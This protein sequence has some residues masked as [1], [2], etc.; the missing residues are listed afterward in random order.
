MRRG[1]HLGGLAINR[2]T[3]SAALLATAVA[4]PVVLVVAFLVGESGSSGGTAASPSSTPPPGPLAT[5]VPA[6]AADVVT[7]CAPVLAAVPVVLTDGSG[8]PPLQ[9]LVV[10]PGGPTFVAWGN[11]LVTLQCG[12]GRPSW[13]R[14]DIDYGTPQ[15]ITAPDGYGALWV[16]EPGAGGRTT[17]TVID[18]PVYL[19]ATLPSDNAAYLTDLSS[20]IGRTLPPVCSTPQPDDAPDAVY[21]G[22]RP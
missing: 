1:Q 19:R 14:D 10:T 7:A 22:A 17:W 13:L 15:L 20:A 3:R 2:S 4:L 16:A 12:V 5:T 18:R 9:P 21:C 11:P 8:D 6:P